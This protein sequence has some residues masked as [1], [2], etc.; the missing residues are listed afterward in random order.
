MA[1]SAPSG[2]QIWYDDSGGTPVDITSHVLTCSGIP[3]EELTEEVGPFGRSWNV[4]KGVG[5]GTIPD[6]TLGGL[7]DDTATT[8]PDALF[9]NRIPE[10]PNVT[11]RTLKIVYIPGS[12]EKATS[13]ETILKKYDRPLDRSALGKYE[14][15][16]QHA[17]GAVTET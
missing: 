3:I 16:L 9:A 7:Y 17:G 14:V 2:I 5:V 11:T 15:T 6:I 13:I 8:G 12:P 1:N 4:N 10:G